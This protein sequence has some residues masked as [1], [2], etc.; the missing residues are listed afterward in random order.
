[1]PSAEEIQQYLSGAWRMM[2]GRQDGLRQLDLSADGFWNS[3]FAMIVATPPL[4]VGWVGYAN[5]FTAVSDGFGDRM[6]IL[7]RLAAIDFA[8]WVVPL[9]ALALVA[10]P[11]GISDRFV[12]LVVAGNW[13]S[14]VIAWIML[15]PSLL[16]LFAP[17][18]MQISGVLSLFLFVLTMVMS[19]R[20]TNIALGK[21]AAVATAVFAGLFIASIAV[22]FLLQG[23]FG[24]S[25]GVEVPME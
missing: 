3:F 22:L 12:H 23:A 21:G 13:A 2:L 16:D 4:I 17:S 15:P 5:Q 1:M 20:M 25:A 14:A 18:A 10:K 6:S 24:L 7:T 8:I 9:I 19:W 11:A